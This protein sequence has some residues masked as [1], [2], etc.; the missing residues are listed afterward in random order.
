MSKLYYFKDLSHE[1]LF[2]KFYGK[3]GSSTDD[4]IAFAY[5]SS[6]IGKKEIA[7]ALNKYEIDYEFLLQMSSKW[8]DAEKA[9][10]E[11]AWQ[12][13]SNIN[14]YENENGKEIQFTSVHSI[15]RSLDAA[16]SKV[17]IEAIKMKYL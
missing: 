4:Y 6:A 10:L 14:L 16:N 13:F 2:N 8:S 9:M 11:V 15:F 12:L 17:V 3:L 7:R 5:V 1:L